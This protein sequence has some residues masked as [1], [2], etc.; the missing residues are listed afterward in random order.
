MQQDKADDYVLA[1]GET[2]TVREFVEKSFA[3]VGTTIEWQGPTGTVEEIGVDKNDPSNVLVR[4]DPRY[5]RP[6]EAK[7][8]LGWT[9]TTSFGDLVKEM[10]E[11]DVKMTKG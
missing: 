1:T 7:K 6:T 8:Q 5:F 2:H 3:V 9:A 11:E 10:V 4:I